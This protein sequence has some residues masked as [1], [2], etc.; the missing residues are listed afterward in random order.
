MMAEYNLLAGD[1][2]EVVKQQQFQPLDTE[3]CRSF[4]MSGMALR[5]EEARS[6]EDRNSFNGKSATTNAGLW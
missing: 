3:I 5:C 2:V 6:G 4:H 1:G